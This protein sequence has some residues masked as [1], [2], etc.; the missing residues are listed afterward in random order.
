MLKNA[1]CL[2]TLE[3]GTY[4]WCKCGKSAKTPFCDGSHAG[5]GKEPVMFV[6]EKKGPAALCCC[7]RTMTPPFCDG[8]HNRKE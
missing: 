4:Y 7:T 6:Q 5:T 2:M 8:A 3:R 1:P